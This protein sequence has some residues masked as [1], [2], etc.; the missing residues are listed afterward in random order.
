MSTV[1]PIDA[2][3]R[4]PSRAPPLPPSAPAK[5]PYR[6]FSKSDRAKPTISFVF[7]AEFAVALPRKAIGAISRQPN[8]GQSCVLEGPA[9][10]LPGVE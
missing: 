7:N 3:R 8:G 2:N 4:R 10:F 6:Q 1:T 5:S 9:Y